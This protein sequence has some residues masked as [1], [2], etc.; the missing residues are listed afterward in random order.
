ME[1]DLETFRPHGSAHERLGEPRR[2]RIGVYVCHCGVNIA[3]RVD[4]EALAA[5][6]GAMPGVIVSRHYK[7]MCSDPGQ[8]LIEEDIKKLGL[9]R[10]VVASCSPRIHEKT[11]RSACRRAGLNPYLFQMACIRE[12]VSWVTEDPGLA[13]HKAMGLVAAA[14]NRTRFQ[15]GLAARS[16]HVH[17]DVLV[18][19]GGIAGMQAALDIANSGRKV[20]L[21]E[22]GTTLGGHMLQFDK[23]FPTLDCAACIGTPKMVDVAQ[24]PNIELL[25]YSEVTQIEGFVG[26]YTARIRC[27]PRY[28]RDNC[29]GCGECAIACPVKAPS[30]WDEGLGSRKAIYRAFPQA[31]PITFCIDKSVCLDCGK[32][33][34]VCEAKAVDHAMTAIEREIVVGS[35]ILATGYDLMNPKALTRYGHG[36]F[37]NVFTSLEFERL[38]NATGP[39]G[40]RILLRDQKGRFSRPPKSV[41]LVHCV[42]SR[43][44]RHHE[45]CSRVCCMAAL[46]YSH[47]IKEKVGPQT[48]VY[49]FYI[50]LR[51][52]GKGYEEFL[53]RCQEEGTVFIRGKASEIRRA[54]SPSEEELLLVTAEDTLAGERVEIPVEMAVLCMAME[55]RRDAADTGRIYGVNIGADGFFLE[56]HP[57][58]GP[59]ETACDGIFLAG[60][61]QS[62]K[63]IPDTA[64]QA[65]GA[66]AKALSLSVRGEVEVPSVVAWIDPELCAGCRI[67]IG[68]CAYGAISFNR[69]KG[70]SEVNEA[71]CKGCGS[72]AGICPSGAARVRH[73]TSRQ[74]FAE[75]DGVM[76][77]E[78]MEAAMAGGGI[79]NDSNRF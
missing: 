26:N 9:N 31:V 14:V 28:V 63:D 29:T 22:R 3:G 34:K 69:R 18:V 55:A 52:F 64:A 54:P 77:G 7:F 21:V 17:P 49:D 2:A 43:D 16:V 71:I 13:L 42:G 56:Q 32:C 8:K 78:E 74:V 50:D 60:A 45:Y 67:C 58:L 61:C 1:A 72:C 47:L 23:T 57:K 66:A 4:V 41:A 79:W 37:R 59:L 11:F 70:V 65:S 51:C 12:H 68:L 53:R 73:F 46:K 39:T 27:N 33:V 44:A 25:T 5:Y 30:E 36:R 38:C 20:Y 19:G 48:R 62:P 10:V 76:D 15:E 40:G 75:I 6:T 24:N 35:I